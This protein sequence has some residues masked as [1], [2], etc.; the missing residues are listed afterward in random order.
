VRGAVLEIGLETNEKIV[1]AILSTFL[2]S[3]QPVIPNSKVTTDL[4][5][6][7]TDSGA[8][9]GQGTEGL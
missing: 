6:W 5:L 1:S 4:G 8:A 9:F 3:I 7:K 2:Q